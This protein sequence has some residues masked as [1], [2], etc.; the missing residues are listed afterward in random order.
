MASYVHVLLSNFS[1]SIVSGSQPLVKAREVVGGHV[2]HEAV[3]VEKVWELR[4]AT[5]ASGLH[6]RSELA[7]FS[8][9]SH[10]RRV[11]PGGGGRCYEGSG[12]Q[13]S[14]YLW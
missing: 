2:R 11:A 14:F 5:R 10:T 6:E 13:E 1:K 8:E 7:D 4:F 12:P 9:A 3:A